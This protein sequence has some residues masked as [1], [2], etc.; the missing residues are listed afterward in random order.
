MIIMAVSKTSF[1]I[2]DEIITQK[3]Y[4]V[5]GQKVMIDSDLSELYKVETK[6]LNQAVKRNQKRFPEDFMFQLS[7]EEFENLR[8][9]LV[10]SSWGGRRYP[11]MAF[12]EQGVAMLSS[13]LRSDTAIEVNIQIIRVFARMR[14]MIMTNKDVLLKLEQL[15]KEVGKHSEDIELIFRY[16]KQ[17]LDPPQ[18][19]RQRIGF[20]QDDK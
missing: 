3:I 18:L 1:S 19:P 12:T 2:T 17:L 9:Q 7:N 11:P 14:Q 8:S 16:L 5:R 4:L 15:E 20:I 10:T 13:V 6:V